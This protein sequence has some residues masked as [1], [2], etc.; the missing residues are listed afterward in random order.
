ME[1]SATPVTF[2]AQMIPSCARQ[3]SRHFSVRCSVSL[4]T[5]LMLMFS[6]SL[7]FQGKVIEAMEKEELDFKLLL[8]AQC[9][10]RHT[11]LVFASNRRSSSSWTMYFLWLDSRRMMVE[12]VT[13]TA[14]SGKHGVCQHARGMSGGSA[15]ARARAWHTPH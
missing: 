1:H 2:A 12:E 5:Y 13:K 3:R 15:A 9:V 6:A 11:L 10:Q 8:T 14:S 7:L 4:C